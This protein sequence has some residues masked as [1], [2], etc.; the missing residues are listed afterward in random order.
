[1]NKEKRQFIGFI[2]MFIVFAILMIFGVHLPGLAGG[3][4]MTSSMIGIMIIIAG[5]MLQP[6]P[7][8]KKPDNEMKETSEN[9]ESCDSVS[10]DNNSNV[11]YCDSIASNETNQKLVTDD[12]TDNPQSS[13]STTRQ[14]VTENSRLD[15]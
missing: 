2:V 9:I 13:K 15:S 3:A 5:R 12:C 6:M 11:T 1:M 8:D 7:D 14:Q 4:V 10:N